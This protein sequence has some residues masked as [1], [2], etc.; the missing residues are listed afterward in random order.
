MSQFSSMFK[1]QTNNV[2][3]LTRVE[4]IPD[5]D[6]LY[7]ATSDQVFSKAELAKTG[8]FKLEEMHP[9]MVATAPS[10]SVFDADTQFGLA[11]L[12]QKEPSLLAGLNL[13]TVHQQATNL[14]TADIM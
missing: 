13:A 9:V 1:Q 12:Q 2:A 6:K 11:Q 7:S 8:G 14:R 5:N 3:G 10:K 4:E